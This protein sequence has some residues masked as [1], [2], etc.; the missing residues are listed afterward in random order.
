MPTHSWIVDSQG[1]ADLAARLADAAWTALD[2]ESNS[3]FAYRE[4]V[5]LLTFNVAG[6]LALVDPFAL[7]GDDPLGPLRAPLEDPARRLLLHGAEYDVACIKRDFAIALRGVF[8]TQQAASL[9]GFQRT[10]YG[11]LVADLLDVRLPKEHARFDW[12]RRPIPEDALAYA[13]DDV[14]YLPELADRLAAFVAEADIADEVAIACEAVE[15]IPAH[16]PSVDRAR[17]WKLKGARDLDRRGLGVLMALF[18]WREEAAADAD[19]PSGRYI[20]HEALVALARAAPTDAAALREGRWPKP[21]KKAADAVADRVRAAL[22][23]PPEIPPRPRGRRGPPE[24]QARSQRLRHW[25][26]EEARQ[27]GVTTQVVLPARALEH[28]AEHGAAGFADCPQLGE[29]R[30]ERYGD[31]LRGLLE[32]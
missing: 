3:Y 19:V 12:A 27:R 5:C 24:E 22:D 14:V 2:T 8:D 6:H 4:R 28:L 25:R 9:L 15:D 31:V 7:A 13:L 10:G 29:R 17:I 21:V 11:N 32:G 30:L 1:V 16:D 23:D 26:D 20:A 18:D